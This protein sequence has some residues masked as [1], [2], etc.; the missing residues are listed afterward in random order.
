MWLFFII[1]ASRSAKLL[2][3]SRQYLII[4]GGKENNAFLKASHVFGLLFFKME[5]ALFFFSDY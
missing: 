3:V 1:R 5:M 2:E 4:I